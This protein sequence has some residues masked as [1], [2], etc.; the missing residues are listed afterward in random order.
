MVFRR[1]K[2]NFWCILT[3]VCF[4][5]GNPNNCIAQ[6]SNEITQLQTKEKENV[7]LLHSISYPI[8]KQK[9]HD[10]YIHP[11]WILGWLNLKGEDNLIPA[12]TR[13]NILTGA[14]ELMC[15]NQIRML[16]SNNVDMVIIGIRIFI[17]QE[18]SPSNYFEI[19]SHGKTNL[20]G[21]FEL[22]SIND[23]SSAYASSVNVQ[24]KSTAKLIYF[25]SEDGK[26][27]VPLKTKKKTILELMDNSEDVKQ[28]IEEENLKL[29]KKE[30]LVKLFDFYN[31]I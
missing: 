21:A 16:Q 5:F 14:V 3:F 12:M 19:L 15:R 17:P 22:G 11:E 30:H 23:G 1:N 13:F 31:E 10:L 18:S 7:K 25:Y 27:A 9:P 26:K 29:S 20:L 8:N 4:V 24:K 6:F 2:I 28:F